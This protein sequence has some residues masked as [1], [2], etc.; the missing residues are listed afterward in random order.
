[1]E[2]LNAIEEADVIVGHN[3][4]GFD[5]KVFRTRLAMHNAAMHKTVRVV[6]TLSLARKLKFNSNKLDSLCDYFGIGRKKQNSGIK[7]W[8]DCMKGN[9]SALKELGEY[10]LQDVILVEELYLKLRAYDTSTPN[11]GLFYP[12]SKPRCP[13]CGSDNLQLTSN[14]VYNQASAG[15]EGICLDCG[16]RFKHKAN[17]LSKKKRTANLTSAK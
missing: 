1:M 16:H 13:C 6:D 12:D 14:L 5:L 17:L 2:L 10:N 11:L 3:I 4:K 15:L 8:I 9:P 7:L